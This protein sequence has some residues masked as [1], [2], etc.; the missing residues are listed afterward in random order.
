MAS[1]LRSPTGPLVKK[2]ARRMVLSVESTVPSLLISAILQTIG[3][4]DDDPVG[5]GEGVSVGLAVGLAVGFGEGDGE[6]VI[7]G[8]GVGV[9]LTT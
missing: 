4:G 2:L 6:G 1:P 9:E 5:D 7:V 3:V 8:V